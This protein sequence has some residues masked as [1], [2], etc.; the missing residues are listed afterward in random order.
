MASL[1]SFIRLYSYLNNNCLDAAHMCL[2]QCMLLHSLAGRVHRDQNT[3]VG[4]YNNTAWKDV[5]EDEQCHSIGA[6]CGV[7]IGQAPVD[8]TSGAIGLWSI[9]PPVCQRGAGE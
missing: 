9:F 1:A 7:L 5:A 4:C 6:C 8:A 2:S 3:C